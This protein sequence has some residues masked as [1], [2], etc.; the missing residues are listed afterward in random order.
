MT[1]GLQDVPDLGAAPST[2]QVVLR[3]LRA[4]IVSGDLA[5][6]APIGQDDVARRFNVSK[7]PVREALKQLEAEGFVTFLRNRGAVV[8]SLSEPEIAQVFEVRAMLEAQA[9]KLAVPLMTPEHLARAEAAAAVFA[10]EPDVS[11]WAARNWE[12]HSALYAPAGR[13]FL[14]GLIR[15]INDRVAR[16]LRVQLTVSGGHFHAVTEHHEILSACRQCKAE[17][18][19]TLTHDHI[20]GACRS[21]SIHLPR[22]D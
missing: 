5:E 22:K 7:I 20:M 17:L 8:A 19:A 10:A 14:M 9:I 21:L 3:H 6:G 4:A 1:L 12:F 15:Q 2:S 11:Q 18:A 16:F 13:D